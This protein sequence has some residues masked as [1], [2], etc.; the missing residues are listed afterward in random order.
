MVMNSSPKAKK[1]CLQS[2]RCLNHTCSI[3]NPPVNNFPEIIYK[4]NKKNDMKRNQ[5]N[6]RV[7]GLKLKRNPKHNETN[8]I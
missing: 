4:F 7:G 2:R 6:Q 5:Y 1:M 3:Y 8:I